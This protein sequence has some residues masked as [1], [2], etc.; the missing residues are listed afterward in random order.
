MNMKNIGLSKI[1]FLN[2]PVVIS[3]ASS[4]LGF[5]QLFLG[6]K[7]YRSS[8][9]GKKRPLVITTPNPEQFVLA[10]KQEWFKKLLV[11]SD[12]AL[13][14]GI[15]VVLGIRFLLNR[16]VSRIAGVDFMDSLCALSEANGYR[17]TLFGGRSDVALRTKQCLINKYPKIDLSVIKIPE[18][19]LGLLKS[20]MGLGKETLVPTS[21][22]AVEETRVLIQSLARTIEKNRVQVVFIALGAPKQEIVANVLRDYLR[23][24]KLPVILMTVGGSFDIIAGVTPRA[25]MVFRQLGLEWLW[26]LVQEP[27]RWK[28]Q[29]ALL[30]YIWLVGK[31]YVT[32]KLRVKS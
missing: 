29:L 11:E 5:S 18:I 14:D 31:E 12:I 1:T 22:K 25:P 27:W 10:S 30:I 3:E 26:R 28:R 21:R 7:Q 17:V 9:S 6:D 4:I 20:V 2:S 32:I 24:N 23:L 13:P 8:A 19:D 16:T 15:G